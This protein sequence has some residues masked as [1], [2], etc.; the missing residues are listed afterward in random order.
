MKLFPELIW[1]LANNKKEAQRNEVFLTFDDGPTPEVTPWV[2]D[3]LN[4]YHAKGTF[5]CLG[6]NVDKYPG[7]Y[8]QI[9]EAGHSVGNHTYSHLQ[10][11]KA[12]NSEYLNDIQ[13]AGHDIESRLFRPPYGR[14]RKS[15]IREIRKNYEIVMWDLLSGDYDRNV[16]PQQCLRNIESHI[17]PGSI[18]VFHDSVKAKRN[19]YYALPQVLEKYSGTY[20]FRPIIRTPE[21]AVSSIAV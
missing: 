3:C 12:S 8:R 6:R 13:L 7:I 2:L 9:I 4:E 11:W 21:M 10:G 16:S 20:E 18:I 17:R 14:F 1:R 5:F 15:Q 19:L